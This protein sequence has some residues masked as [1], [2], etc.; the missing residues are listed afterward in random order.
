MS[1]EYEWDGG[2]SSHGPLTETEG[3]KEYL[4]MNSKPAKEL[5]EILLDGDWM[6]SLENYVFFRY[7]KFSGLRVYRGMVKCLLGVVG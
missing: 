5:K 4:T 1:G 6:K 7:A 2:C 3:G